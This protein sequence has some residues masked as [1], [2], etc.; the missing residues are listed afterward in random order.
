MLV[1]EI[2]EI[3]LDFHRFFRGRFLL[4]ADAAR[5]RTALTASYLLLA[6]CL[7][8]AELLLCSFLCLCSLERTAELLIMLFV[9]RAE[10]VLRD[11]DLIFLFGSF[12]CLHKLVIIGLHCMFVLLECCVL[13][14]I[15]LKRGDFVIALA[16]LFLVDEKWL[17]VFFFRLL[18]DDFS[19]LLAVIVGV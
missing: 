14:C 4:G 6:R 17:I 16:L 15:I 12:I 11:V 8:L 3:L 2:V 5:M 13:P 1:E 10:V 9:F 18:H 7:G 19:E